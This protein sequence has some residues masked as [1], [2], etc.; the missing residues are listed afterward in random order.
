MYPK[1]V[2]VHPSHIVFMGLMPDHNVDTG[3]SFTAIANNEQEERALQKPHPRTLLEKAGPQ[4]TIPPPKVVPPRLVPPVQLYMI[5]PRSLLALP[6]P[7]WY[8]NPTT[9]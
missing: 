8:R 1:K 6:D 5:R 3:H 2:E 4:G 9:R 7:R